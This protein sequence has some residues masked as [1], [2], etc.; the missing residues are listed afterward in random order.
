MELFIV[1]IMYNEDDSF[2][3]STMHDV[4]KN[5]SAIAARPGVRRAGRRSSSAAMVVRRSTRAPTA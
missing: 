3:T 1:M 5:A 4:M 2:F